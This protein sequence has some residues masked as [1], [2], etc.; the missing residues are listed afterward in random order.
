M[1]GFRRTLRIFGLSQT[2]N[3][4]EIVDL[5]YG[6]AGLA[7]Q[8][9]FEKLTRVERD[10]NSVLSAPSF[11]QSL[12]NREKPRNGAS[13]ADRQNLMDSKMVG[14]LAEGAIP[15]VRW[16]KKIA[17]GALELNMLSDTVRE[18]YKHIEGGVLNP[19][20]A[21]LANR[22]D[23]LDRLL[24]LKSLTLSDLLRIRIDW[25]LKLAGPTQKQ[26]D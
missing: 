25:R 11:L 8:T 2:P 14:K 18:H 22:I 16:F 10:Y 26:I 23:Q 21:K 19:L 6:A 15:V 5:A 20:G 1:A 12:I 4:Q 7:L 13:Y 17:L 24:N 3:A 9:P